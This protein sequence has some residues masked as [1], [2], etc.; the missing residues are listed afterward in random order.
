MMDCP[1]NCECFHH[2]FYAADRRP[3][4]S[5]GKRSSRTHSNRP[6]AIA[7]AR[8]VLQKRGLLPGTPVRPGYLK[9][10]YGD[11]GRFAD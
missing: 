8:Y 10:S 4:I 11:A 2:T 3:C 7:W 1:A 5:C 9:V 6:N